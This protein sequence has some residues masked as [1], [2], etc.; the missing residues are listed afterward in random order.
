VAHASGVADH[1]VA[2]WT[3]DETVAGSVAV[4]SAGSDGGTPSGDPAP[5]TDVP[6]VSFDD[7][8]SAAFDGSDFFTFQ[9][10]VSDDFSVCAWV[11]TTSVGGGTNHWE[12]APILDS[13][14]GGVAYDF[15]FGVGNGGKLMFGNG[16][17]IGGNLVDAQVNGT[18]TINDDQWH[19]VC[20]TRDESTGQ[21]DLYVD[22]ALDGSGVTGTGSL[23]SNPDARVGYGFDGAAHFSGLIDDVRVYDTVLT[24]TELT[25][26][27]VGSD[28]PDS[29]PLTASLTPSN[30]ATGVATG[31]RLQ[32]TFNHPP[33]AGTGDIEV[34]RSS[35]GATAETMAA[36]DT[37]HVTVSESTVTIR[38]SRALATSSGYYVT[39]DADA[40]KNASGYF[41]PGISDASGWSFTTANGAPEIISAE[42]NPLALDED[43]GPA[44]VVLSAVDDVDTS[45]LSWSVTSGAS[46][47]TVTVIAPGTGAN[48]SF[49]YTPDAGWSGNDSFVVQ[50]SDSSGA[51][52]EFTVP[53]TVAAVNHAPKIA[54]GAATALTVG[55]GTTATGHLTATDADGDALQW[56]VATLPAHGTASVRSGSRGA[57][58]MTYQPAPGF[59]GSDRF[60]VRV[61]D[62]H[63]GSDAIVVNVSVR[64][65]GDDDGVS[66]AAEAGAPNGGDANGDGVPDAEQPSVASFP[67]PRTGRYLSVG[68]P[69]DCTLSDAGAASR[70][71]GTGDRGFSYPLGLVDFTARCAAGATITA[72]AYFYGA[73]DTAFV[74]RKFDP[75]TGSYTSV[76]GARLTRVVI[77]GKSV[78]RAR[79]R[80]TDG[81]PLDADGVVNGSI[82]DPVGLARAVASPPTTGTPPASAGG[83]STPAL[84]TSGLAR[85]GPAG[86]V[87]LTTTGAI[88]ITAGLFLLWAARR[89]EDDPS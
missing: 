70:S 56:A 34:H 30:G 52:D 51:T 39:V 25:N 82:L 57:A 40:F 47:G 61:I 86:I 54:Q 8:R 87:P 75:R 19:N 78:V 80:V 13:E 48:A 17:L 4:D 32:L 71:T 68:V 43:A 24:G 74:V 28:D 6:P 31:T 83:T 77:G 42:P 58:T 46:H 37:D 21:V 41:Y 15:G 16:G 88:A 7:V 11:K 50:A 55:E 5:S 36:D 64:P 26:L 73:P 33:T 84:P 45:R 76:V 10:P 44:T 12:S 1:L 81:G 3:F 9:R 53:V 29:P 67:D 62:G 23:D 14:T 63:G 22:A 79:Y 18:T 59:H 20:V 35:D 66:G 89:R 27:T 72:T 49:S 38:L 69:G 2:H 60:A 65:D 85:T